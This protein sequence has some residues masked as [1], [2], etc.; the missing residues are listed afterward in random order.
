MDSWG[1]CLFV[2]GAWSVY[3]AVRGG[4]DLNLRVLPDKATAAICIDPKLYRPARNDSIS[5]LKSLGQPSSPSWHRHF[6]LN[7]RF[8]HA[9]ILNMSH[10]SFVAPVLKQN[11]YD[12]HSEYAQAVD[13]VTTS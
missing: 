9:E 4:V 6:H 10:H 8:E 1:S 2:D 11:E 7:S 5:I 3:M 12:S 13:F